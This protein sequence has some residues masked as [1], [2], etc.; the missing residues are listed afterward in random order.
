[1]FARRRKSPQKIAAAYGLEA[2]AVV[3]QEYQVPGSYLMLGASSS[4]DYMSAA[5]NH[6]PLAQFHE[7]VLHLVARLHAELAIR[8]LRRDAVVTSN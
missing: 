2:D 4:P 6:N 8:T 5:D 1:M 3:I 7:G